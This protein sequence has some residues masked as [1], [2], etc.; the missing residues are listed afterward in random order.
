[1]YEKGLSFTHY[2]SKPSFESI[3]LVLPLPVPHY[4]LAALV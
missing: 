2:L 4:Q 1:M 3:S